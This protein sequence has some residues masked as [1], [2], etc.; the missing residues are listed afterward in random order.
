[1]SV[2]STDKYCTCLEPTAISIWWGLTMTF[3]MINA[4]CLYGD[5]HT[6]EPQYL[7]IDSGAELI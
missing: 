5:W 3:F 1:M 4:S 6:W 2:L 7:E